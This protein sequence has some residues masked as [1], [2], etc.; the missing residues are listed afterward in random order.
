MENTKQNILSAKRV[1]AD[2]KQ[3]NVECV[4]NLE[5]N[6]NVE[7]V[8]ALTAQTEITQQTNTEKEVKFTGEIF[9]H[10]FYLTSEDQIDSVSSICD[11]SD[12][13][14][15]D[16]LP[17]GQSYRATAKIVGINPS[18]ASEN[19]L[20]VLVTVEVAFVLE[21]NTEVNIYENFDEACRVK[22]GEASF[23]SE[24]ETYSA[25]F[26]TAKS[27]EVKEQISKVL[28]VDSNAILKS[29]TAHDGFVTIEGEVFNYIVYARE[30][31]S[32]AH[33][34]TSENFK[35]ELDVEASLATAL[36]EAKLDLSKK[37]IIVE[38]DQSEESTTIKIVSPM[39]ASVKLYV[40]RQH[41]IVQDIYSLK[42]RLEVNESVVSTTSLL[43]SKYFEGKVEGSLTLTENQPRI[44]KTLAVSNSKYVI[45]NAYLKDDEIFVEGIVSSNLV[46]LNDEAE[47][48]HS[49]EVEVP[50]VTS[51]KYIVE[52]TEN[53]QVAV[54][55]ALSDCDMLAK[56][57][58][59]IYFDCKIKVYANIWQ[60]NTQTVISN[61]EYK[62]LHREKDSA[63]EIYFAKMGESFWDIAKELNVEESL[64]AGQ[65]PG[66]SNPLESDE[67]IV[68]YY[69]IEK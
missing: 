61:V 27:L 9:L 59:E 38:L 40:E 41:F 64:V 63:I 48:V 39:K 13:L 45:S 12:A 67:K 49:V 16:V 24:T 8:L 34:Q 54:Q 55:V 32:V 19:L 43:P 37:S 52:N 18:S 1:V 31:G 36:V 4:I 30:D 2:S 51:E 60:E 17:E 11:Y 53:T 28:I 21:G 23:V 10:L 15:H 62:E 68:V 66:V 20:K 65:N 26:E 46:Y 5:N 3:I 6:Q 35:E 14:K 58:R 7:K 22:L 44:D 69:G 56:R 42:N 50:F 57:G 33:I 25:N 47:S 29:T